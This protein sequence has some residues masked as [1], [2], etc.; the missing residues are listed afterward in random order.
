L[1]YSLKYK[2]QFR[3]WLW[4]KVREPNI[5][6]QFHPSRLLENLEDEDADLDEALNNL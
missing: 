1:F 3:D 6:K 5:M 4:L 2:K